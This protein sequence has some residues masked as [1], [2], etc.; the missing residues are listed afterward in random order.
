MR[1]S[2][3]AT[4]SAECRWTRTLRW[5]MPAR[6]LRASNSVSVD[7]GQT[8]PTVT[9]EPRSSGR[10]LARGVGGVVRHAALADH[11]G[12][13]ENAAAT[14]S[15][16][17]GKVRTDRAD[18]PEH[19]DV[20][21]RLKCLVGRFD[22]RGVDAEAGVGD[23]DVGWAVPLEHRAG[24][25]GHRGRV[26]HV[27]RHG[28]DSGASGGQRLEPFA[29]PRDREHGGAASRERQRSRAAD[30]GRR[31]REKDDLSVE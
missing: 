19:I 6:S 28:D 4:D 5:G 13:D 24:K 17:A 27:G 20:E 23:D 30:A 22:E 12:D 10:V 1:T 3:R 25:G 16:H 8:M 2:E 9:P 21:Q 26:G 15:D 11:R 7:D 14:T 31:P 29:R 18:D